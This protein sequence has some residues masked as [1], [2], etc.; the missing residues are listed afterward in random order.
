MLLNERTRKKYSKKKNKV[1]EGERE[2]Q[3]NTRRSTQYCYNSDWCRLIQSKY[4]HTSSERERET[5]IILD[6]TMSQEE[7]A[8]ATIK[9]TYFWWLY[10]IG[11]IVAVAA[12]VA[13]VSYI[14]VHFIYFLFHVY[15]FPI[16]FVA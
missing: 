4:T 9:D 3:P 5:I 13:F 1:R 11:V 15:F 7:C 6:G 10:H 16:Y 14:Y 8:K 2:S 12:A